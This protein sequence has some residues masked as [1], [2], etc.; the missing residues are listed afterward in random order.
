M[1]PRPYSEAHG[2]RRGLGTRDLVRLV[3]PVL[4]DLMHED[5]VFAEAFGDPGMKTIYEDGTVVMGRHGGTVDPVAFFLN[6]VR[7][8]DPWLYL[9]DGNSGDYERR[10]PRN[11]DEVLDFI[12][13]LHEVA[14]IYG[15]DEEAPSP[16]AAARGQQRLRE[17]VDPILGLL[18]PP[19]QVAA[20]GTIVQTNP[21]ELQPLID[22]PLP[23]EVAASDIADDVRAAVA[24]FRSRSASSADK[25]SACVRLAGVLESLR[26]TKDTKAALMSDDEAR[27]F[28]IANQF[29]FR[30]RNAKQRTGYDRE[31]FTEWVFFCQLAAI[32]LVA[33]LR[34]RKDG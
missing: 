34:A 6:R 8:I 5:L 20:D 3:F 25:Q 27:L 32:R 13:A 16:I 19:L 15:P 4:S 12:Q 30:H 10:P 9:V 23:S 1:S 2:R 14:S 17:A 26:D 28:E 33:R 18:Q 7:S 29:G 24:Q 22:N 11:A 21:R 31:I